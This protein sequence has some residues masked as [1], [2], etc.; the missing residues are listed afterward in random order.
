MSVAE[1]IVV[2]MA[3]NQHLFDVVAVEAM[4]AAEAA[5]RGVVDGLPVGLRQRLANGESLEADER[6]RVVSAAREAIADLVDDGV[7]RSEEGRS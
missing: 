3:V 7:A 4:G 2:L 5:V 1:Q 6:E